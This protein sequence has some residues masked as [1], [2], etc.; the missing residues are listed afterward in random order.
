MGNTVLL[1]EYKLNC[2]MATAKNW[3]L[4]GHAPKAKW[5]SKFFFVT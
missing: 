4:R 3:D 2:A 5:Y 1:W